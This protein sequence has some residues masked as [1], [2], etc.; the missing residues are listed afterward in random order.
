MIREIYGQHP[1]KFIVTLADPVRRMYS[2]YYFILDNL[3][4]RYR[5]WG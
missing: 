3:K 2:D 1:V 4:V 5:G